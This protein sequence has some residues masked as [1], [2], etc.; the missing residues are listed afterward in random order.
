VDNIAQLV[1]AEVQEAGEE[2]LA[3]CHIRT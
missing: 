3:S 1:G 2:Q